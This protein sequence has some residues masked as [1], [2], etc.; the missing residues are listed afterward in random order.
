[1][2]SKEEL[3]RRNFG[4]PAG[5]EVNSIPVTLDSRSE[6][7]YWNENRVAAAQSF[8]FPVYRYAAGLVRKHG[9]QTILDIGCGVGVKL[10]LLHKENAGGRIV[11]IDQPRAVEYC[12]KHLAFG[13]WYSDDFE[14]P[15][16]D[17]NVD[18]DL[19]I[20]ADVIEHLVDPNCLLDYARRRMK[21]DGLM[22]LSTPDR[23]RLWGRGMMRSPNP[24]HVREWTAQEFGGYLRS[25]GFFVVEHFHQ[26][27]V[28]TEISRMF[29]REVVRRVLRGQSPAY[30]QVCLV[31]AL[32]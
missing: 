13:E 14:N 1:M 32:P 15:R 23:E 5:Y 11:G 24:S 21:P 25:R 3:L 20:A 22:L 17:L 2:V 31:K 4:I 28:K 30:N 6:S 16:L 27:P 12:Q 29:F 7:V 10:A 9:F 26:L 19:V 18:A 8:Q